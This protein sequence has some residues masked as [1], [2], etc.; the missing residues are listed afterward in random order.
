MSGKLVPINSILNHY[1]NTIFPIIKEA[2]I[3]DWSPEKIMFFSKMIYSQ[4]LRSELIQL[5]D[6]PDS[7]WDEFFMNFFDILFEYKK[8]D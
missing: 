1:I 3:M 2:T 8:R 6:N 7:Q 5:I 4:L